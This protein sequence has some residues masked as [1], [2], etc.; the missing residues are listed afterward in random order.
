MAA[1]KRESLESHRLGAAK[2]LGMKEAQVPACAETTLAVTATAPKKRKVA[3]NE[4]APGSSS[5]NKRGRLSPSAGERRQQASDKAQEATKKQDTVVSKLAEFQ[6][7][8]R[9]D[10]KY[11]QD[12]Q[13]KP[14]LRSAYKKWTRPDEEWL[15]S[16][17]MKGGTQLDAAA[18]TLG[19]TVLAIANCA[20]Q[21]RRFPSHNPHWRTAEQILAEATPKSAA[22][23]LSAS[24]VELPVNTR[25]ST[26]FLEDNESSTE[27]RDLSTKYWSA[28][29]L[30][31]PRNTQ[32]PPVHDL[33][34]HCEL[35][36]RGK[37]HLHALSSVRTSVDSDM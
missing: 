18:Q 32:L 25:D 30:K 5:A 36:S 28:G 3:N 7:L 10:S 1:H 9:G 34:W 33:S 2:V 15:R 20:Q 23:S 24:A 29:G 16:F 37:V 35:Q 14:G 6:R 22:R 17:I 26:R 12:V 8:V 31:S 11:V 13:K 19:R 27:Q 4:G 21:L